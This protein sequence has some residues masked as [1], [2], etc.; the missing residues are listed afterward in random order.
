MGGLALS[1]IAT[2][3]N[4]GERDRAV[5][6]GSAELAEFEVLGQNLLATCVAPPTRAPTPSS[7]ANPADSASCDEHAIPVAEKAKAFRD[8]IAISTQNALAS[9]EGADQHEQARLRQ[10]KIGQQRRDQPE[11][12][13]RRNEDL[14]L[15]AMGCECPASG[16]KCAVLQ[17]ANHGGAHGDDAS[18]LAHRA[19]EG[20][21][22]RRGKCVALAMQVDI[23]D[24]LDAQRSKCTQT[25]V[26]GYAR[27]LDSLRIELIQHQRRKVQS[28]SGRGHRTALARIYGLVTLPVRFGIVAV[29][30]GRQRDVADAIER[31]IEIVD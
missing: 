3:F 17:R 4:S 11:L 8:R 29:N 14:R 15:S 31:A 5:L 25:D 9:G 24:A 18:S 21:S 30:I 12:K 19:I 2:E 22:R 26:Q 23:G 27:Y 16:L 28:G 6:A 20:F 10:V 7:S 1:G 13:S